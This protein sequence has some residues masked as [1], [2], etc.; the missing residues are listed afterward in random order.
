MATQRK[1]K[2]VAKVTRRQPVAQQQTTNQQPANYGWVIWILLVLVLLAIAFL[3]G[4]TAKVAPKVTEAPAATEAPAQAETCRVIHESVMV[5]TMDHVST[6]G[7]FI[8]VE[9][10]FDGQPERETILDAAKAD[11][12]AYTFSRP[13][14]GW[15]WE[16]DGCTYDEVL[17]QV[18]ANITRRLAGHFNNVGYFPYGVVLSGSDKNSPWDP[19]KLF[20]P[21]H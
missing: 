14:K 21:A 19:T 18:N 7:D 20:V 11:G 2:K 5:E 15:V 1:T 4:R 10:W 9:Y 3:V 16:Y 6:S 17:A 13:L 12:G 8:H